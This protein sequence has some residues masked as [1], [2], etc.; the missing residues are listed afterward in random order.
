ML[1]RIAMLPLLLALVA[2]TVFLPALALYLEANR[3]VLAAPFC[4]NKDKPM[5]NCNGNCVLARRLNEAMQHTQTPGTETEMI[6]LS[7]SLPLYY[8]EAEVWQLSARPTAK[9]AATYIIPY[10]QGREFHGAIFKPPR[11]V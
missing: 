1:K 10:L 2:Q 8:Q 4:I 3:A 6:V 9:S 5:L 11:W 7:F